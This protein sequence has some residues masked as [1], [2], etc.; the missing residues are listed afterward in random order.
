MTH[1]LNG[2]NSCMVSRFPTVWCIL[3]FR[4]TCVWRCRFIIFHCLRTIKSNSYSILTLN[5]CNWLFSTFHPFGSFFQFYLH[6]ISVLLTENCFFFLHLICAFEQIS[7]LIWIR[8]NFCTNWN[9]KS[10]NLFSSIF[11]FIFDEEKLSNSKIIMNYEVWTN[12]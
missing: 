3:D 11:F 10:G 2:R 12:I 1:I 9:R 6:Q 7:I 4:C 5:D 8:L